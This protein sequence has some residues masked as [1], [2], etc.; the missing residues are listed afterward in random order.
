MEPE[1]T[2]LEVRNIIF[3]TI[4]FRFQLLIFGVFGDFM[5]FQISQPLKTVGPLSAQDHLK[6]LPLAAQA[7]L[8]LQ[9]EKVSTNG[10]R[11]VGRWAR[12]ARWWWWGKKSSNLTILFFKW[13]GLKPPT[14]GAW[15]CFFFWVLGVEKQ[16]VF[17]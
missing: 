1:N 3:Q 2:L 13:V 4:I 12:R 11:G 14:S 5:S 9:S 7:A 10:P 6:E 15:W 8:G 16:Q 17:F